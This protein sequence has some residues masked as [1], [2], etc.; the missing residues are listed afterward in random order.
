[1][2]NREIRWAQMQEHLNGANTTESVRPSFSVTTFS[3]HAV[4]MPPGR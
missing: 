1:M 3:T 4:P 2:V